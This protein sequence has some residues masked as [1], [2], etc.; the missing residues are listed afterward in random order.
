MKR[1]SIGKSLKGFASFTALATSGHFHVAVVSSV[2]AVSVKLLSTWSSTVSCLTVA[3]SFALVLLAT[4]ALLA[5]FA[6]VLFVLFPLPLPLSSQFKS[7]GTTPCIVDLFL[8]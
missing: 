2:A 3:L 7:I 5:P 4:F 1:H 8:M 6:L